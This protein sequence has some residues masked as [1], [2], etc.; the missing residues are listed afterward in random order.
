MSKRCNLKNHGSVLPLAL[1]AV[2]I[3][4][5]MGT[6]L[7]SMGLTNRMYSL[8]DKTDLVAR[9]AADAGAT[10]ALFEMNNRLDMNTLIGYAMPSA[11]Q[12]KLTSCE[13]LYSYLVTGSLAGGYKIT[14]LGESGN[15]KRV[16]TASVG[17]SGL[18][19]HAILV[20][21]NLILKSGTTVDGYNSSD[22]TA[23]DVPVNIGTES[24]VTGAVVL[25]NS[26]IIGGDVGVG[27]NGDIEN[28]IKDLGATIEGD[29]YAASIIYPMPQVSVP[30]LTDMGKSL[31][32]KGGTITLTP[33]ESGTYS[34][35]DLQKGKDDG[36]LEITGGDVVLHITGDIELD[37]S[38]EIVVRDGSTLK[39]YVD[40]DIQCREGSGINTETPPEQAAT[41]QLFATGEG[42]QSLDIKAKSNWTGTIYAPN[43]NVILFAG[44]DAYGSIVASSF[45]YKAGGDFHYD[46]AL[47]EVTIL[48]PG[49]RFT[50]TQWK[51]GILNTDAVVDL[52]SLSSVEVGILKE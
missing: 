42:T 44:T 35:I 2:I 33:A 6:A 49:V 29:K 51:E 10:E 1:I 16:V 8:R 28:V 27:M 38:C 4:L 52:G 48:D 13:G 47:K 19:D 30:A 34:S 17:L 26:V 31:T 39:I 20:K 46:A 18:F 37:Q 21:E 43:G 12:T 32:S 36:V 5:M 11:Y 9:C 45:E 25:N 14:S 23:T 22:P 40:G 24:T 7:L 3:L 41:L 15:A 50:I